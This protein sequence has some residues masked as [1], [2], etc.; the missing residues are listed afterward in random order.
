[1]PAKIDAPAIWTDE[2]G[3]QAVPVGQEPSPHEVADCKFVEIEG[4][5]EQHAEI[6]P[7]HADEDRGFGCQRE[8]MTGHQGSLAR[9]RGRVNGLRLAKRCRRLGKRCRRLRKRCRRLRKRCRRADI[10]D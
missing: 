4:R 5:A 7:I 6:L 3:S 1:M 10:H 9:G 8:G 2:Q